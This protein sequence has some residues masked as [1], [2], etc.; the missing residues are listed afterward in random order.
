M[1]MT[2]LS[3]FRLGKRSVGLGIA[4]C[5]LSMLVACSDGDTPSLQVPAPPLS[6]SAIAKSPEIELSWQPSEGAGS[7]HLYWS[8]T[9]GVSTV[10]GTR[11]SGVSS[12]YL[13]TDLTRGLT[14][15]YVVTA[16]NEAGE[17]GP[18]L[19]T[20]ATISPAAPEVVSATSGD[21]QVTLDWRSV[22]GATSYRVYWS[23]TPGVTPANGTLV[24]NA[25]APLVH[26][27]LTNGLTYYYIVSAVNAGG[28]G[29]S[30]LQVS[31]VPQEPVPA[32]P[33]AVSAIAT[34]E[35][36]LSLTVQWAPPPEPADPTRVVSY[37]LYRSTSPGIANNLSAATLI[38]GVVSP[39]IDTVPAGQ[40]A[41][42]YVISA[43]TAGGEGPVSA[44]V[45]AVPKGSPGGSGGS[46]GS[47]GETSFGNNLSVPLV[48]A[49][50]VGLLGDKITGTDYLDRATG[51][52]PSTTDIVDPFPYLNP[53]DA[54]TLA[55]TT[56]YRQQSASTW[57]AGWINGST[58]PQ[59]VEVDWGDNLTSASLSA[60]QVLRV[61]TV[62][63]QYP[64]TDAW[65]TDQP[66]MA[67]PMALLYG[68]GRTEMQ[69]TTGTPVEAQERRV[70]TVMARLRIRKLV[71]G[72][73][74]D[75]PCGF[76][77]SVADGFKIPDGG[78]VPRYSAE[79]NV[80]GSQTYG[81]NWR[82]NQCTATDKTGAWRIS[83][84][85]D[86]ASEVN[87]QGLANNVLLESLHPSE[88][89]S[90]LNSPKET[91][92]DIEVR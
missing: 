50:G 3:G 57:Q 9:A 7:Y 47:P 61:E 83:F 62:L 73:P 72:V 16:A 76:N 30:S 59:R 74:T 53:I 69:G 13:H 67:Y 44:E 64:N 38:E 84:S 4:T 66:L 81:F 40:V 68:T 49:D 82:L 27:G 5:A 56:Y 89:R 19:E 25:S 24:D 86:D 22:L 51:L 65:P 90:V 42:Y 55:G 23:N 26:T 28:E 8:T 10:D 48:F 87:G 21:T 91:S 37:N 92:I 31:A 39:H 20:S 88:T 41:Y 75:H 52:R 32:A 33:Q 2:H 1:I 58:G 77:G 79:I 70:F 12:P 29:E 78:S 63:R 34:P 15:Y 85:L 54:Y 43:V 71:D 6:L 14:Y 17:S 36:T 18:S 46:G 45:S 11:I 60:N 80:G 35:T